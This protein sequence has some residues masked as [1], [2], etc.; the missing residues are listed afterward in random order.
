MDTNKR[1]HW[2]KPPKPSTEPTATRSEMVRDWYWLARPVD[3]VKVRIK[4]DSLSPDG[5]QPIVIDSRH[6]FNGLQGDILNP[7]GSIGPVELPTPN[8]ATIQATREFVKRYQHDSMKRAGLY[9]FDKS[10]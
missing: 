7:D 9:R 4:Y 2:P 8:K 1:K 10:E 3:G 6:D 5:N